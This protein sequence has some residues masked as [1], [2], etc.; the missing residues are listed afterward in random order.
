MRGRDLEHDM[1]ARE[2]FHSLTMLPGAWAT[3]PPCG[4]SISHCPPRCGRISVEVRDRTV[5]VDLVQ[6]PHHASKFLRTLNR[7]PVIHRT[8]AMNLPE[9]VA[10][11]ERSTRK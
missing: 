3:G 10:D 6:R 4:G 8:M 11:P 1:R 2:W 7:L 5:E 9:L